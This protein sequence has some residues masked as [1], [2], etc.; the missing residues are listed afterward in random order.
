MRKTFFTML[1]L[2][3]LS[4]LYSC[5]PN[6]PQEV[7]FTLNYTFVESGSFFRARTIAKRYK[8]QYVFDRLLYQCKIKQSFI[9]SKKNVL[10]LQ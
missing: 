10:Y 1:V 4:S 8:F 3:F 6:E 2:A 7:D 5:S 9:I